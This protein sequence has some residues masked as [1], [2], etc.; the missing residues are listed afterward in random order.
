VDDPL[1]D[2]TYDDLYALGTGD[3]DRRLAF[4]LDDGTSVA[5]EC[6]PGYPFAQVWVPPGAPYAALEPM[7]APT[8][9][10]VAGTAPLV[11]PGEAFTATFALVVG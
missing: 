4:A 1:G 5:L 6:G 2:R 7:A 9:A 8:D 10:L 11:A 3:D